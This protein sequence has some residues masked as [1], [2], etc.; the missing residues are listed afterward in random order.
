MR[1]GLRARLQAEADQYSE[2]VAEQRL[3][4]QILENSSIHFP[5]VLVREEV[6]EEL[7]RLAQEL[8]Q[9]SVSYAQYL[10][11][12]GGLTPE[13]HQ[14]GIAQQAALQIRTLLALREI[15]IQ[16]DL[17]A[18]DAQVDA[19]FERLLS[20]NTITDEQYAEYHADQRRRLQV[21]NALIQQRLHDFLFAHN[22][23]NPVEQA[24]MP[25][26]E[27]MASEMKSE[28]ASE[29]DNGLMGD[30]QE[31]RTLTSEGQSESELEVGSEVGSETMP[32]Q[33]EASADASAAFAAGGE[34]G[35]VESLHGSDALQTPDLSSEPQAADT[36]ETTAA[37]DTAKTE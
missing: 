36:T 18:T 15:S 16:E 20:A 4:D 14:V 3:F 17:Q 6:E 21:A 8:R 37:Q 25:T 2:Q 23:I 26:E 12:L 27:E 34:A 19:E 1:E 11:N 30:A 22:T 10:Q 35:T 31:P 5:S 28:M 29:Q 7:R 32:E 13:Q 33:T 24:I 9:T